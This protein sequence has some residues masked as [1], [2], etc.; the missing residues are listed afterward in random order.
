MSHG[1]SAYPLSPRMMP[2]NGPPSY[3]SQTKELRMI[4]ASNPETTAYDLHVADAQYVGAGQKVEDPVVLVESK[5]DDPVHVDP[6]KLEAPE[7]KEP[8]TKDAGVQFMEEWLQKSHLIQSEN[9]DE[10]SHDRTSSLMSSKKMPSDYDPEN[11]AMFAMNSRP[12][13]LFSGETGQDLDKWLQQ[14]QNKIDGYGGPISETMKLAR[15]K[16]HLEGLA[17]DVI[18]DLTARNIVQSFDEY[19]QKLRTLT[20]TETIRMR[21]IQELD[22][23]RQKPSQSLLNTKNLREN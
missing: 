2:R 10:S 8:G 6:D 17:Y 9:D 18:H 15:L 20:D 16:D 3:P 23:V 11:E 21:A 13:P 19:I 5:G 4:K 7:K 14:F 1:R 22:R 12:I